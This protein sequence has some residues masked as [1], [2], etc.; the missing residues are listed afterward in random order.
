MDE[1]AAQALISAETEKLRSINKDLGIVS[2]TQE[3]WDI[4]VEFLRKKDG[5]IYAVRFRCDNGFPIE[6][7]AGVAFVNPK[8]RK[9]E[10][11]EFWPDDGE[12]AVK[13]NHNPPFVCMLGVR[14]YHQSPGNHGGKP[15]REMA[16][17]APLFTS[18][19][20]HLNK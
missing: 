13:R 3:N 5:K 14:E 10:G 17:L 19:I 12:Q 2:I 18:L 6:A 11:I 20:I 4:F 9:E 8:T 1:V 16:S 15:P 7:C